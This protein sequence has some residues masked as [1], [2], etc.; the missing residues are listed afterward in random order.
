MSLQGSDIQQFK[1]YN[2]IKLVPVLC[3]LKAQLVFEKFN[4]FRQLQ[5]REATS[6]LGV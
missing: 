6:I 1:I 3:S 5:N 4:Q 2:T